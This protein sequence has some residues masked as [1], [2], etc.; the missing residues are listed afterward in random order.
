M[1]PSAPR[2]T[3]RGRIPGSLVLAGGVRGALLEPRSTAVRLPATPSRLE[4][5]MCLAFV[6]IDASYQ[7]QGRLRR[8]AQFG[9]VVRQVVELGGHASG[10]GSRRLVELIAEPVHILA[11]LFV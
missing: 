9:V 11:L 7:C 2:R 5:H 4:R 8:P 1:V 10:F 6:L 3:L